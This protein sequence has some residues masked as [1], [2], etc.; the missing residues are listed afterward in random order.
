MVL[1]VFRSQSNT[2]ES[3]ENFEIGDNRVLSFTKQVLWA[4]RE[5]IMWHMSREGLHQF[6][7]SNMQFNMPSFS[8][9]YYLSMACH[10]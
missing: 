7:D 2:E 10:L 3:M 6:H 5:H 1:R 8:K 9:C 4:E